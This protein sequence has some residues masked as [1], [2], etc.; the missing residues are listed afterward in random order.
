MKMANIERNQQKCNW[1]K[2]CVAENLMRDAD[3]LFCSLL[4][5][6]RHEGSD[7]ICIKLVLGKEYL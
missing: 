6:Y 4:L 1:I 3:G 2:T 7:S 5:L